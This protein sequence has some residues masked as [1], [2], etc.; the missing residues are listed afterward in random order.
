MQ[1]YGR[2]RRFRNGDDV[3]VYLF[4]GMII[5]GIIGLTVG[6]LAAAFKAAEKEIARLDKEVSDA[7]KQN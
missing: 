1:S 4:T 2:N 5:G 7:H 3:K 6:S